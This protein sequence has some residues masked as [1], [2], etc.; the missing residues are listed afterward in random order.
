MNIKKIILEEIRRSI[1]EGVEHMENLYKAWANKK[2][3]NPEAAMKIMDDVIS[4]RRSLPKKDFAKYNS[5]EELLKDLNMIKA[6][7]VT[8]DITKFYEDKDLLVIAANTWE[9]SCKYGA[10]SKWCTTARDTD[11][12]WKRHNSTGTEFFWIFKNKPQDDPNHKFSHHIK[13]NGGMDWCNA[14]NSCRTNL[15][16]TS[17][18]KQHP[19]YQ[20]IIEKLMEYHNSRG[21]TALPENLG[22]INANYIYNWLVDNSY[23]VIN[24]FQSLLDI[25]DFI[26]GYSNFVIN[27]EVMENL[28]DTHVIA[29]SEL[30]SLGVGKEELHNMLLK[31]LKSLPF[32]DYDIDT[33]L[34]LEDLRYTVKII[35]EDYYGVNPNLPIQEEIERVFGRPLEI[36]DVLNE[37]IVETYEEDFS[38]ILTE[39]VGTLIID[40][41]YDETD[42]FLEDYLYEY[43]TKNNLD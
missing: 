6:S 38:E 9:S 40:H 15:L 35:L 11:S 7:K 19:K 10:G 18:P 41:Y 31:H 5:Y 42:L 28:Y 8:D 3:G 29:I 26:E 16:E 22:S 14:V 36:S 37:E 23:E 13:I 4:N 32:I 21:M 27:D 43:K 33:D 2:S 34:L 25:V 17:Y 12:Y 30:L 1:F 20:Q 24:T 39:I